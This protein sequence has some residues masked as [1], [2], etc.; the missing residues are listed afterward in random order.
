[1]IVSFPSGRVQTRSFQ[2][3]EC[4]Q[5][6]RIANQVQW[7][8]HSTTVSGL[9]PCMLVA[10]I[11]YATSIISHNSLRGRK[12]QSEHAML[13]DHQSSLPQAL[14]GNVPGF[15]PAFREGISPPW[16]VM[17]A[18]SPSL[19]PSTRCVGSLNDSQSH[20]RKPRHAFLRTRAG[21]VGKTA[22]GHSWAKVLSGNFE[23]VSRVLDE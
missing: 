4:P 18:E 15:R 14:E 12:R 2:C 9:L 22:S 16:D 10:I 5:R 8:S 21:Q 6:S 19:P 11:P 7:S 3:A 17:S 23:V 13:K 1:M 20:I